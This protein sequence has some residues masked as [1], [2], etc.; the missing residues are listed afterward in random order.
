MAWIKREPVAFYGSLTSFVTAVVGLGLA[1]E[2][3]NWSEVQIGAILTAWAAIGGIFTFI[4]RS[5]VS[6]TSGS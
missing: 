4:V 1:F 2:W 5:Q 6:P 3:W